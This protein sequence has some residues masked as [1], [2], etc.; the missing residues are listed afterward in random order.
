MD[1][2]CLGEPLIEL[3]QQADGRYL[4]GI[5]GDT[6]NCAIAAARQG[7]QV[8][9]YSQVGDDAFGRQL[10]QCWSQEGVDDSAVVTTLAGHTGL[11]FVDHNEAGHHFSYLR[12]GSAASLMQAESLPREQIEK[13]AVLHLSGISLGISD[14][15]ADAAFAA[16]EL[17]RQAGRV[18]SFDPNYRPALWPITRARAL[19][20]EAM[21]RCQIALPGL[22][23]ARLLTGLEDPNQIAD[24]YLR[25]GVEIVALTLGADGVLV[26]T[27]QERK[28]LP[29]HQVVPLDATGAGDTFDG[30]FLAQWLRTNDPFA[31][32][33]YGNAAAALS[34]QGFGAVTPIPH[35]VDV[36]R[37]LAKTG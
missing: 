21:A 11:Y 33:A 20:H 14:N 18:V 28:Q 29:A 12:A 9:Y 13:A 2:L 32:A 16:I 25:L 36:E 1:I 27:A 7:A 31:A 10:R 5:G 30:T 24:F 26:A 19:I 17:A 23:D 34:T 8:A 6:S 22:D 3:N 15:A 4:S 35:R 37:Q